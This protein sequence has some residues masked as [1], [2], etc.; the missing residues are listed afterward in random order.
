MSEYPGEGGNGTI[1]NGELKPPERE[2]FETKKAL[3]NRIKP[4][5]PENH[6]QQ[7]V[8]YHTTISS[9]SCCLFYNFF[10]C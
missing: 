10:L 3:F 1:C 5:P 4:S 8:S 9:T 7:P 6:G 2:S